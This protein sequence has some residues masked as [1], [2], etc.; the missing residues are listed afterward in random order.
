MK[1]IKPC[2]AGFLLCCFGNCLLIVL[3]P[4]L[5]RP[6]AQLGRSIYSWGFFAGGGGLNAEGEWGPFLIAPHK[7]PCHGF[8]EGC[9]KYSKSLW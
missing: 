4:C 7:C 1:L 8:D 5:C 9:G 2:L 3:Q 6:G